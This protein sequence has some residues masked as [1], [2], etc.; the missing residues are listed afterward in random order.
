MIIVIVSTVQTIWRI[1]RDMF[2]HS[3]TEMN[4]FFACMYY[5]SK[6]NI[7]SYLFA[8]LGGYKKRNCSD[9]MINLLLLHGMYST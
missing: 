4:R 5:V 2:S 6:T 1:E 7:I 9:E 8:S 3:G